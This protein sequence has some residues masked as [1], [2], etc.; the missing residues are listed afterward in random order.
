MFRMAHKL[1]MM[2]YAVRYTMTNVRGV[3]HTTT[4]FLRVRKIDVG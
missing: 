2:M 4:V 3:G 1:M